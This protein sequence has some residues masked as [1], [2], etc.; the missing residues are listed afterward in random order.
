MLAARIGQFSH[1]WI[2][3]CKRLGLDVVEV[4]VDWGEGVPVERFAEILADD[5]AHAIKAVL[6]T[7]NETATGV[8]SECL[9]FAPRWT[10]AIIPPCSTSTA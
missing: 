10:P 3:M 5:K 4:D 9:A 1:L 8:T 6:V 7:H 2:E